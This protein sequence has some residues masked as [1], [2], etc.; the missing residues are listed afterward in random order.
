MKRQVSIK[1]IAQRSGVSIA[2]VSRVINKSGRYSKE[3]EERILSIIQEENYTPNL[4]AKGLRMQKTIH[5]GIIVP[6]ITN[7]FFVKLANELENNLFREGYQAI[8]CN[9]NE[10]AQQEK[11]RAQMMTMQNV[12]GMIF[13]CSA[14]E[15]VNYEGNDLPT[16]FVER[17]PGGHKGRYTMVTSDN[18][19][20]GYLATRE[21]LDEGC[22]K[23]LI[24]MSDGD[25]SGY[26]ERYQGYVQAL[27]EASLGQ[28]SI[29]TL[30]L[31]SLHYQDAYDAVCALMAAGKFDYDGVFAASDWLALGCYRAL[32]ENGV[33]V[34]DT[35]KIVGYD[36]I[37]ITAFNTVPITTIHQ[38][39][40]EL[41]RIATEHLLK[42]IRGEAESG[43]IIRVPV[44]LIPRASTRGE[45]AKKYI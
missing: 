4:V 21:L 7:E 29:H 30:K 22:K 42:A 18:V 45:R 17:L 24:I 36:N 28:E 39:V 8:L 3:T 9:T 2:T 6:D 19:H 34:P 25:V 5:I 12:S 10:N 26:T 38:Q 15:N 11:L 41:G 43:G 35:V 20:G 40:D 23:I 27:E 37:S 33:S 1:D 16:V 44:Q 14:M 13:L 31:K 32:E